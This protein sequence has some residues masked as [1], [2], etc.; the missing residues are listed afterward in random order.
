MPS[1]CFSISSIFIDT[2]CHTEKIKY[3]L[4][5]LF[6]NLRWF[7]FNFFPHM[8]SNVQLHHPIV[9]W[10][11]VISRAHEVLNWKTSTKRYREF[12]LSISHQRKRRLI[13]TTSSSHVLRV[14]SNATAPTS[15]IVTIYRRFSRKESISRLPRNIIPCTNSFYIAQRLLYALDSRFCWHRFARNILRKNNYES[16]DKRKR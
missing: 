1:N 11:N 9:S 15:I 5:V 6:L 3:G 13:R 7:F 10:L 16:A 2:F 14:A 8:W 12:F 4:C